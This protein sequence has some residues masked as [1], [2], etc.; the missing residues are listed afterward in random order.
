MLVPTAAGEYL[1]QE[2]ALDNL[3]DI[4]KTP[5]SIARLPAAARAAQLKDEQA[6][7]PLLNPVVVWLRHS[8]GALVCDLKQALVGD[9]EAEF[10]VEGAF[11][12]RYPRQRG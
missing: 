8:H 4:Q 3:R 12:S 11:H 1:L 6:R 10:G 7:P 9:R 5:T 2:L